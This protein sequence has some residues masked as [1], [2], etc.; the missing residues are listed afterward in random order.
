MAIIVVN[1]LCQWVSVRFVGRVKQLRGVKL[2]L[3]A[4]A[5]H[6]AFHILY[7]LVSDNNGTDSIWRFRLYNILS[8][9]LCKIW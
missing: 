9:V 8:A 4:N 6:S 2:D 1:T 7:R 5:F 3:R